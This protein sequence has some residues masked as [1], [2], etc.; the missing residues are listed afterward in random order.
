LV[1]MMNDIYQN[2]WNPYN[3]FF[4]PALKLKEKIR[5]G[6]RIKKVYDK[7]MTPYQRL[8]ESNTLTELQKTNLKITFDSLNPIHLKA[9]LDK[10][11]SLF[12]SNLTLDQA[13][14]GNDALKESA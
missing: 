8:L 6:G 13:M 9:A 5:I 7:P 11:M 3:N 12:T 1:K 2:F 14:G 10:K 4:C